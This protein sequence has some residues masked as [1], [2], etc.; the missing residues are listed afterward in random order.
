M[1]SDAAAIIFASAKKRC[2]IMQPRVNKNT[3]KEVL[4]L[5][6]DD[7]AWA[8]LDETE[9]S[10]GSNTN[11]QTTKKPEDLDFKPKWL[12]DGMEPVLEELP[13]WYLVQEILVEIEG[14]TIKHQGWRP[15][16]INC[17]YS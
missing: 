4:D 6:E 17:L 10:G 13:K 7:D 12:P 15:N 9:G 1:V 14:E 11:A 2:Y 16:F 8:A 3:Q 5:T